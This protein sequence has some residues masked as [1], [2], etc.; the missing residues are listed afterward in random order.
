MNNADNSLF[1]VE[2]Y[3]DAL[4]HTFVMHSDCICCPRGVIG[5]G[6]TLQEAEEHF[7]FDLQRHSYPQPVIDTK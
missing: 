3:R 7:H 5:E 1:L 2:I 4:R 6:A